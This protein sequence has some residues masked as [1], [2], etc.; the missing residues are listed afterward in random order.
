M[1]YEIAQAQLAV[2]GLVFAGVVA[3][4]VHW[5]LAA[6]RWRARA[7]ERQEARDAALEEMVI[8]ALPAVRESMRRPDAAVTELPLPESL[9]GTVF[10]GRLRILAERYATDL[11]Q[12]Q[13][14]AERATRGKVR[15][16]SRAAIRGAVRSVVSTLVST[17]ADVGKVVGDAL[18]RHPEM[19]RT[20]FDID[21][22]VQQLLRQAQSLAVVCGGSPGRRW[23]PTKLTDVVGGAVGRLRD[24]RRVRYQELDRVVASRFVEPLILLLATLLDNATRYSPPKSYVEVSFQ[25]GHHGVT[26]VIDDA[27]KRMAPGQLRQA[28]RILAGEEPAD[29]Y[30]MGP[31]PQIGF[32]VVAVLAHRHRLDVCVH[33]GPS[34]YGGTRVTVFVP[35]AAFTTAADE[36]RPEPEP[37]RQPE[38]EPERR[39]DREPEAAPQPAGPAQTPGGLPRRRRRQRTAAAAEADASTVIQPGRPEAAA[40]WWQAG[41]SNRTDS[42]VD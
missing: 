38:S 24:Y 32:H 17:G 34:P 30:K 15:E 1:K 6:R 41:R 8:T 27:G 7:Q 9:R 14:E 25:E 11:R 2:A 37:E 23:P 13:A 42:P 20:L 33:E 26:V 5:A 29:L 35:E 12:V 4:A 21:H 19:S 28:Q 18:D 16:E 10:A 22:A 31:H 3:L 39:P 36:A 40:A